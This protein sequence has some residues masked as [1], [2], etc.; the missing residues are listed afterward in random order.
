MLYGSETWR[1]NASDPQRLHHNDRSMV[2]WVCSTKTMTNHPYLTYFRN[3]TLRIL[4]QSDGQHVC[5]LLNLS[6]TYQSLAPDGK[7]SLEKT[8]SVY[9]MTD[10]RQCGLFGVDPHDRDAWKAGA[11][12]SRKLNQLRHGQHPDIKMDMSRWDM[13]VLPSSLSLPW[14]WWSWSWSSSYY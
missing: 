8:W 14:W 6:Q 5:P 7:R 4:R 12:C 9:M 2:C 10:V 1:S 11:W 3:S 13:D